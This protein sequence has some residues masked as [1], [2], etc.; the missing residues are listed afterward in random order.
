MTVTSTPAAQD[1]ARRLA[2]VPAGTVP[3]P[4]G[5]RLLRSGWL[6]TAV[7]LV[8]VYAVCLVLM[9]FQLTASHTSGETVTPGLNG[10]AIRQAA[11]YAFPTLAVWTVLFM[12]LDRYRPQRWLVWFLTVGWGGAVATFIALQINTWASAKIATA[13]GGDGTSAVSVAVFVA[14]FVEEAC[15]A[16]GLFALAYLVR[17]RLSSIVS[18]IALGG[19]S[20]IGFAFTENIIY[21]SRGIVYGST[22][23]AAGDVEAAVKQLVMLRGVWTSFGHPLFTS[24]TGIGLVIGLR[25]RSRIV[26]VLAPVAGFL[27]AAFLH[28]TFNASASILPSRY[29]LWA[30]FLVAVPFVLAVAVFAVLQVLRQGRLIRSRLD[31]YVRAGWLPPTYPVVFSRLRTRLHAVLISPWY[32]SP[33]ATVRL[34]RRVTE[35]AYLRDAMTRGLVDHAGLWYEK[36]LLAAIRRLA[37][38]R[39]V[40]DP[41][42]LRP[43]LPRRRRASYPAPS[44]PGPAG[45]GGVFPAMPGDVRPVAAQPLARVAATSAAALPPAPAPVVTAWPPAPVAPSVAPPASAWVPASQASPSGGVPAA[46]TPPSGSMPAAQPPSGATP[47]SGSMP[48]AQPPSGATP[49]V[50]AALPPDARYSAVNPSWGPPRS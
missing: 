29:L 34:Q 19:L 23:A 31:D 11:R 9:W 45:I 25:S 14:P 17:S 42:G 8:V 26:R 18:G 5:D 30:Y 24:M 39:A 37:A 41:T 35:L 1:R 46:P 22:T 50:G 10:D 16:T 43:Y 47:P 7:G 44:Y 32:G 28:M 33:L 2:G 48:A 6:W 3:R 40:I 4:L 49:P 13:Q 15:K 38:S 36:D 12:L 27:A 21:Y 20:G